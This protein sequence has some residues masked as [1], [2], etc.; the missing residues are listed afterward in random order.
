MMLLVVAKQKR[1]WELVIN[2]N[3]TC[4]WEKVEYCTSNRALLHRKRKKLFT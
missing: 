4:F 2:I 3:K 1:K